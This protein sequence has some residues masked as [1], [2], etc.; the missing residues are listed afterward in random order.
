MAVW[1]DRRRADLGDLA[2]MPC[3]FPPPWSVDDPDMKLG[4]V[5]IIRDADGRPGVCNFEDQRG[6]RRRCS[7][8]TENAQPCLTWEALPRALRRLYST[9]CT[10]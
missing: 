4:Q 1:R 7:P 2:L 10:F 5:Y 8:A 3:R 9:S 6:R